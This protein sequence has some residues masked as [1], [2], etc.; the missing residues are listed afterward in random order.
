MAIDASVTEAK[1]VHS[2]GWGDEF[3]THTIVLMMCV[4][5][6]HST[7]SSCNQALVMIGDRRAH[8]RPM[9]FFSLAII[10]LQVSKDA[11]AFVS[12]SRIGLFHI[13]GVIMG[14]CYYISGR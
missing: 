12:L 10:A 14:L 5:E 11:A 8:A 1:A 4:R 13:Y 9:A 3:N 6:S 2:G 7:S